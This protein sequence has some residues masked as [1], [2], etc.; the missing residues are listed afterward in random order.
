MITNLEN[1]SISDSKKIKKKHKKKLR[2]EY[3]EIRKKRKLIE[4]IRKIKQTRNKIKTPKTPKTTKTPKP[5]KSSLTFDDY[6]QECI[7]NKKI[8]K[9]TPLYFRKALERAIREHEQG[10]EKEKSSLNEF[11]NK[12]I[13]KPDYKTN[14]PFKFI[15]I[16]KR[17]NLEEFLKNHRNIKMSYILVCLMERV[18][19]DERGREI[20]VT[21]KA[22]FR[23]NTFTNLESDDEYDLI[24]V[25]LRHLMEKVTEYLS[26]GSGWYIKKIIQLEMHTV[27]YKPMRGGEYIALPDWIMR[28]KAIVSLRNNDSKCFIWSVLRYLHPKE[29]ND[30][31][32][33]D[34]KQYEKEL[35]TKGLD[36]PLKVK[37][38]TKFE[39]LNPSIPGINVFSVNGNKKFYPLRMANKD[40]KTTIDLFYY[41]SG[42]KCHYSIIKNFSRLFR[43]Q[44]TKRTCDP[45][46]IC[47][48][49]FCHFTKEELLIKHSRYCSAND[50]SV[51]KMPPKNTFISFKNYDKQLPIPFVIYADFECFTKPMSSC[52]PNPEDS[53]SYNYQKHEPSGFCFYIKGIMP[54]KKFKPIIYAKKK[55]DD[56]IAL[57]FVKKLEKVTHKLYEDFYLRSRSNNIIIG[58]TGS[59]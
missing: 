15:G 33:T 46:F 41:E 3:E 49:C 25:V 16:D 28:K 17:K 55:P 47:K 11:A 58:N 21:T 48:R 38:I 45:I 2:K 30:N 13:I 7:K 31:R 22:Y 12:Y 42:G 35:V 52:C 51:V 57:I 27:D 50:L 20:K 56:N 36:F 40:Y 1:L 26:L 4:Q 39:N 32:I 59:I 18:A 54:D 29:K 19:M 8:P 14:D 53:Y 23:T 24:S 9:D 44:I 6:F 10:I 37:D 43:S 34:L 5:P